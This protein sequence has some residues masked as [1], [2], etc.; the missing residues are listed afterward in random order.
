MK[1]S[2]VIEVK[3]KWSPGSCHYDLERL[4][5]LVKQYGWRNHGTVQMG[6]LVTVVVVKKSKLE[7]RI[8]EI[9]ESVKA[10]ESDAVSL[11]VHPDRLAAYEDHELGKTGYS[12]IIEVVPKR[13][14]GEADEDD[15][16]TAHAEG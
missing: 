11:R 14:D 2:G 4:R 1:V 13:P 15:G 10:I 3:R 6:F 12:V 9:R 7:G 8:E 16:S 5:A